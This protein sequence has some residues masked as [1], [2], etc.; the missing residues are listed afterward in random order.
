[1]SSPLPQTIIIGAYIYFVTSL[2]PRMMENKKSFDL[3]KVLI[4]YNFGVV[5]LSLYMCYEVSGL[6][7]TYTF[8]QKC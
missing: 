6:Q 5:A 8:E 1:M 7:V 4:I 2:G 3:K